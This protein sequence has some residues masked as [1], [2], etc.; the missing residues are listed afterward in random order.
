MDGGLQNAEAYTFAANL[1]SGLKMGILSA[2]YGVGALISPLSATKFSTV[3]HWSFH[4]LISV[5]GS[6]INVLLLMLILRFRTLEGGCH[7]IIGRIFNPYV[8]S[9]IYLEGRAKPHAR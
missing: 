2:S 8:S 6:V 3:S 9:Q 4:Y 5:A 7:L 1:N